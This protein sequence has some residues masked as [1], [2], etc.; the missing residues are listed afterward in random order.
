MDAGAQRGGEVAAG[1][2]IALVG[3]L[4]LVASLFFERANDYFYDVA[5][6]RLI[7]YGAVGPL[8]VVLVL[9]AFGLCL[10]GFIDR[11]PR[12]GP[13]LLLL[14]SIAC[15]GLTILA[16]TDLGVHP[17][18]M[19]D[20]SNDIAFGSVLSIASS[21]LMTGGALVAFGGTARTK[22]QG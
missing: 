17:T 18:D 19:G 9:A 5:D 2:A 22:S 11:F 21:V 1:C 16:A 3:A 7:E 12:I 4:F 15:L 8:L 13:L 20:Q 10:L 6:N 14:V